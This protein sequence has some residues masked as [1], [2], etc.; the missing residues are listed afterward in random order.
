MSKEDRVYVECPISLADKDV[1]ENAIQDHPSTC[2]YSNDGQYVVLK[3]QQKLFPKSIDHLQKYSHREFKQYISSSPLWINSL[4]FD[5][6]KEQETKNALLDIKIDYEEKN[7]K[8]QTKALT[9]KNTTFNTIKKI[10]SNIPMIYVY[11][12]VSLLFL[13]LVILGFLYFNIL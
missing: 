1:F 13:I 8:K 12:V 5:Q 6:L 2:M 3:F 9:S 10:N 7:I 4:S 11:T